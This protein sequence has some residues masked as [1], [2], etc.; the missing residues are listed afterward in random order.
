MIHSRL[1]QFPRVGLGLYLRSDRLL[2]EP[3]L[4]WDQ[5]IARVT[6]HSPRHVSLDVFDTVVTRS[7]ANERSVVYM[8]ASRLVAEGLWPSSVEEYLTAREAAFRRSGDKALSGIYQSGPLDLVADIDQAIACEVEIEC[9]LSTPVPGASRAVVELRRRHGPLTY[10]SDMHLP[11][12]AIRHLL[13]EAELL[14]RGDRVLVSGEVGASKASGALFGEAWTKSELSSVVHLGNNEWADG[15]RAAQARVKPLFVGR[16]NPTRYEAAISVNPDSYG[17]VIGGAGRRARLDFASTGSPMESAE[18]FGTQ[19]IGIVMM[20]FLMW[21]RRVSLDQG[22]GNTVFLA[23]DGELALRMAEAM[24]S[25]FWAHTELGYLHCGRRSWS[26]AA[27]SAMGVARWIEIGTTD[28]NAFLMHSAPTLP[29]KSLLQ[30]V[31]LT[32]DQVGGDRHLGGLDPLEPLPGGDLEP[33][34]N[35]LA[36]QV[37]REMILVES[38]RQKE[39]VVRWLQANLNLGGRNPALVDVGWR[40]QQSLMVSALFSEAFGLEPLHLHFAG[41][42]LRPEIEPELTIR[43]FAFDD[44]LVPP[45]INGAIACME[46]FLGAGGPRLIGYEQ[47]GETGETVSQVFC[48]AIPGVATDTIQGIWR[49]A[50]ALA[51][52]MPPAEFVVA[53][54]LDWEDDLSAQVRELMMLLWD[55]PE[56]SEAEILKQLRLELD[57]SGEHVTAIVDPYSLSQL[58][59][60]HRPVRQWPRGSIAASPPAQRVLYNA[61]ERLRSART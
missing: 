28:P 1:A 26:V 60:G 5:I 36:G 41:R 42:A 18:A 33:W 13:T 52:A 55:H 51:E 4:D 29:L 25:S 58:A 8:I 20:A 35:F 49:G 32:A 47:T 39:L 53:T 6:D 10:L 59:R 27:A 17:P 46:M 37:A 21:V 30:R 31:G 34:Q 44:D 43:R 7:V 2:R 57:D 3:F 24:P 38:S 23:R 54:G 45:P 61:F 11:T 14:D 16:I 15:A 40:G 9:S 48:D 56:P 12:S 22:T 50:V 19:F